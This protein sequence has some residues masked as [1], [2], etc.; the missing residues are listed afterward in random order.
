MRPWLMGTAQPIAVVCDH[1]NLEY[2]MTS[3]V[4]NR[5]QGRWSMFL[6]EFDFQLDWAP[7]TQNPADSPSRCREGRHLGADNRGR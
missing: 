3:H 4:L 5:R 2:F 6:S 7:G 1:K